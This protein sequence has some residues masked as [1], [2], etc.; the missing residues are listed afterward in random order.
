MPSL[1]PFMIVTVISWAFNFVALKIAYREITVPDLSL[2]RWLIMEAVLVGYCLASKQSLRIPK[3]YVA[4]VLLLGFWMLGF[5]MV[6]FLVGI[7]NTS[8]A[9]GVIIMA[10][11]PIFTNLF[12]VVAKQEK[13]EPLVLVGAVIA[14][15]GVVLV[16][17]KGSPVGGES[18][19]FGNWIILA[20]AATWAAG[21]VYMRTLLQAFEPSHLLTLSMPGA[22]PAL[23]PYTLLADRHTNWAAV[24]GISWLMLLHTA[25]MSGAVGFMGFY[26]G[27]RKIGAS[28]AMLYQYLVPPLTLLMAWAAMNEAVTPIQAV[29]VA[30]VLSGVSFAMAAKERARRSLATEVA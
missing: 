7:K 25:V 16:V 24:S 1:N 22:L 8:P 18:H 27:V 9:E 17:L 2:A 29:G 11:G 14:F 5:Y 21:A 4:R 23:L 12:A 15:A 6:L 28:G 3:P 19:A 10:T 20:A 30:V 13:F 26:A